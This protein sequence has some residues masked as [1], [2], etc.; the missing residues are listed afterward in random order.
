MRVSPEPLSLSADAISKLETR[1]FDYGKSN[2]YELLGQVESWEA[3]VVKVGSCGFGAAG[4]A[5]GSHEE[6]GRR[7]G[8]QALG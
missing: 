6:A 8:R 1:L 4:V 3:R 7:A 2:L 5:T